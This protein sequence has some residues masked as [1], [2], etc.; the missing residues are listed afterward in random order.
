MLLINMLGR[1]RANLI[2]QR[3]RSLEMILVAD[4]EERNGHKHEQQ[5]AEKKVQH[6]KRPIASLLH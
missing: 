5:E 1:F 4:N 3:F 2:R 6:S